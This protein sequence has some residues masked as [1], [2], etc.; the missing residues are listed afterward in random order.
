MLSDRENLIQR[1]A[2]KA[3]DM[4]KN[5][6]LK[7]LYYTGNEDVTSQSDID[8]FG[9]VAP[10]FDIEKHEQKINKHYDKTRD[11]D[12]N[13]LEV[14]FRGVGLDE[15]GGARPRGVLGKH[16]G[17][18][19][20]L[21]EFPFYQSVWGEK[22]DFSKFELK[23]LTMPEEARKYADK[24]INFLS[25]LKKGEQTYPIQNF[26]KDVL[27]LARVEAVEEHGFEF[28]PSYKR[29][30]KHM[31]DKKGHIVHDMM[32]LRRKKVTKSDIL[33]LDGEIKD[34]VSQMQQKYAA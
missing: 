22:Y 8:L 17:L 30:A 6:G 33:G 4:F 1:A 18:R 15:L 3:I 5:I 2:Q 9:I 27:R 32:K 23:P 26:S 28:H 34:Y 7:A 20:L 10:D 24:I 14:N 12:Y 29:L 19:T 31:K 16:I 13:G 11:S 21:N 25:A